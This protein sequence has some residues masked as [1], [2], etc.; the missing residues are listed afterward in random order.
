MRVNSSLERFIFTRD[1]RLSAKNKGHTDHQLRDLFDNLLRRGQI[2]VGGRSSNG[3]DASWDVYIN[4]IQI[5]NKANES[6]FVIKV[7]KVDVI[8]KWSAGG[9]WQENKFSLMSKP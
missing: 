6:G 8:N 9:Y 4:F 7:E 2:N 3:Y 5:V 1:K